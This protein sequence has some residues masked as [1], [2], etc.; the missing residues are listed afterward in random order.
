MRYETLAILADET[1]LITPLEE[2]QALHF[3][4]N[5]YTGP[6]GEPIRVYGTGHVEISQGKWGS[7]LRV[8][9]EYD[10]PYFDG[11]TRSTV[12]AES[13]TLQRSIDGSPW[14]KLA[15][16]L[17]LDGAVTDQL[18]SLL[19]P[20]QYRVITKTSLETEAIGPEIQA[21][22]ERP[23]G[24]THFYLNAGDGFLTV[25]HAPG[26]QTDDQLTIEQSSHQ[27]AGRPDPVVFYGEHETYTVPF[28]GPLIDTATPRQTW[29]Q[30][31]RE[32][33]IVCYRDSLGR[34][35]F[36]TL[37]LQLPTAAGLTTVQGSITQVDYTE[38][39]AA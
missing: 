4:G 21:V 8:T 25:A 11:Y 2:G 16:G 39:A 31:L 30:L 28:T 1:Y 27:F 26:H 13:L 12:P 6:V 19:Y 17:A 37:T 24:G 14:V 22:W 18:P 15:E 35:V 5:R 34:R 29:L 38:G 9:G 33:G 32:R 20:N 10:G 3:N 36:G 7:R 23:L